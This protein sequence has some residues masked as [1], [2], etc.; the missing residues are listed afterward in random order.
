MRL[1]IGAHT[2]RPW[3]IHR[4]APDFAVLDVWSYRAPGA[5]FDDLPAYLDAIGTAR[6]PAAVRLL[7]AIRW[8][9]GQLFGWDDPDVA[10]PTLIDRLPADLHKPDAGDPVP[11]MPF[12]RVYQCRDEA[13]MEVANRTVHGIAHFGWVRT[14]GGEYE[15]RLAVLVKPNGALG[16]AYL[17]AIAPF[18][19]LIVYP[20]MTRQWEAAWLRRAAAAVN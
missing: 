12:T 11:G 15:L 2:Q 14:R 4:I 3:R 9:L 5:G 8:K 6:D 7:F 17:G 16:R 10:G 13:A 20:A 19:H 1:P 18:R